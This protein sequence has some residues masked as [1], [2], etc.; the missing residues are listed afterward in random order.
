MPSTAEKRRT[1]HK[2]HEAGCCVIPNPWDL[3]PT[4]YLQ[5]RGFEAL[6]SDR[7]LVPIAGLSATGATGIVAVRFTAPEKRDRMGEQEP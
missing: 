2:L 7:S 6:A 3:G 4:R 5:Q 1:F